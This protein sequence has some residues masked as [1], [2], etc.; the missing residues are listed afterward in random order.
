M[1]GILKANFE[2]IDYVNDMLKSLDGI[3]QLHDENRLSPL[4]TT[5]L[6]TDFEKNLEKARKQ[7]DGVG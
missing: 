6:L 1:K 7:C 4:T 3:R 2:T 5:P